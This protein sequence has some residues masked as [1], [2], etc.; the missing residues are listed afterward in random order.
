MNKWGQCKE[1][2][3]GPWTGKGRM[4]R[5][6]ESTFGEGGKWGTNNLEHYRPC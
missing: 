2:K 5:V 3:E 4:R 1:M 6:V